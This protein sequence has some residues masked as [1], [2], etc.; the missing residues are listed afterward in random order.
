M[1][2]TARAVGHV[3]VP[4]RLSPECCVPEA[5]EPSRCSFRRGV[6]RALKSRTG[7]NIAA[8]ARPTTRAIA[9]RKARSK[10]VADDPLRMHHS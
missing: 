7:R 4:L 10:E 6:R 1:L 5:T 9:L 3:R 8:T 2:Q